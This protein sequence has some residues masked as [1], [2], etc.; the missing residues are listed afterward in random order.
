MTSIG[1]RAAD[2]PDQRREAAQVRFEAV[3]WIGT[4]GVPQDATMVLHRLHGLPPEE[5]G[6]AYDDED[7]WPPLR[8]Q[9][10]KARKQ[11]KIRQ[12]EDDSQSD[13]DQ[14]AE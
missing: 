6:D 13:E 3:R 1:S 7:D 14:S 4:F 12:Q 8:K 11:A 9:R 5:H 10:T 2:A